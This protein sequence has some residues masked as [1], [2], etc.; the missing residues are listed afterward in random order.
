MRARRDALA[1]HNMAGSEHNY[2]K[3]SQK[4][5]ENVSEKCPEKQSEDKQHECKVSDSVFLLK[6]C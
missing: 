5:S 3:V 2:E 6:L 4:V 1:A